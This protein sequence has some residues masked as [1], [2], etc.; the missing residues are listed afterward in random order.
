MKK[1][2]IKGHRPKETKQL[3]RLLLHHSFAPS[4]P[5]D[6]AELNFHQVSE[7]YWI[8]F[9]FLPRYIFLSPIAGANRVLD[10]IFPECFLLFFLRCFFYCIMYMYQ[11]RN[12]LTQLFSAAAVANVYK[13]IHER[14]MRIWCIYV[15]CLRCISV[16]MRTQS[17]D[18]VMQ[19]LIWNPMCSNICFCHCWESIN[20][21]GHVLHLYKQFVCRS[22][23]LNA[24]SYN[25]CLGSGKD[26]AK[27]IQMR[28]GLKRSKRTLENICFIYI[29]KRRCRKEDMIKK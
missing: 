7:V 19:Y 16:W 21:A 8:V 22:V 1:R 14:V 2:R 15:I 10:I 11:F 26:I 6:G 24:P 9:L 12:L 17:K 29:W 18:R 25:V 28:T 13:Y 27:E 5:E 4:L 3:L 23:R 20:Q